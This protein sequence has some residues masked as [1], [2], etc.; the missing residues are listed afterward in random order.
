MC[1]CPLPFPCSLLRWARAMRCSWFLMQCDGIWA[2]EGLVLIKGHGFRISGTTHLLLL[3]VNVWVVMVQGR[4]SSSL[5][6][7]TGTSVR[8]SCCSSSVFHF[9]LMN[10]F[11]LP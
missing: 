8:K 10:L 3:G 7:P 1:L 6:C 5:S 11:Y 4:W 9:T 2:Q